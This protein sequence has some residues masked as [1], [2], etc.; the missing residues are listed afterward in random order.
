MGAG[1]SSR[2]LPR[3][4]LLENLREDLKVKPQDRAWSPSW[5]V[6]PRLARIQKNSNW[7]EDD[8]P[9]RSAVTEVAFRSLQVQ[10]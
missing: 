8:N 9:T 7:R 4:S 1:H 3:D 2:S 10:F 6:F 5:I